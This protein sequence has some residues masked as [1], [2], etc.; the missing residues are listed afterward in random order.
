VVRV[1]LIDEEKLALALRNPFEGIGKPEPLRFYMQG[2][3]S[4]RITQEHRLLT[5]RRPRLSSHVKGE[6]P[7]LIQALMGQKE[8]A[9][10]ALRLAIAN[11]FRWG[12]W[13]F[14]NLH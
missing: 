9:V 7:V 5:R 12:W 14:P 10:A 13:S 4:R 3:R 8:Q 1:G 11:G 6:R 2:C